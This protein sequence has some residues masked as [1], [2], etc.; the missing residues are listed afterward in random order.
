MTAPLPCR[1]TGEAFEPLPRYRS[2]CDR[3]Y[4]VGEVYRLTEHV[5]RSQAS[6]NHYFAAIAEA[7]ANL[8]EREAERFATD[9]H[10]RKYALIKCGYANQQDF[11]AQSKAEAVRLAAA[12]SSIDEY[13]VVTIAGNVVTRWTAKS[14]SMPAM[15]KKDFQASKQA[16]LDYVAG[17]VGVTPEAL[18]REAG[19]AA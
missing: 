18:N 1:W 8:P 13:A 11:V 3:H 10:L 7:W 16:V 17:L 15:G 14:Q 9:V 12:I 5:E 19:K 6:H 2:E 4:V